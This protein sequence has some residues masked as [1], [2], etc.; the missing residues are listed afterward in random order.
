MFLIMPV[1]V[2]MRKNLPLPLELSRDHHCDNKGFLLIRQK[3]NYLLLLSN[4]GARF[5]FEP[6][7][8]IPTHKP[9]YV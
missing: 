2:H 9:L 6:P 5:P 1:S 7:C 8:R 3:F 4:L